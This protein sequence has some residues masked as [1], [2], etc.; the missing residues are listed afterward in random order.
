MRKHKLYLL[1]EDCAGKKEQV[2]IKRD[3][4]NKSDL[5]RSVLTGNVK[6]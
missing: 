4:R 3:N 6:H 1:E 2:Q 5:A